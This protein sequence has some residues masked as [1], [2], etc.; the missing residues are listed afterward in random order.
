MAGFGPADAETK[1]YLVVDATG[2][3]IGGPYLWDG[4]SEWKAPEEGTLMLE[5]EYLKRMGEE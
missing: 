5:S 3:A 2:Y 1:R 4:V